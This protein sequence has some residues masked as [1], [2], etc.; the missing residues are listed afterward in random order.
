MPDF[1]PYRFSPQGNPFVA[2]PGGPVTPA[3]QLDDNFAACAAAL[4]PTNY[5]PGSDAAGLIAAIALGGGAAA[6][7][8]SNV[9]PSTGRD[10]L[11]ALATNL[12]N[13]STAILYPPGTFPFAADAALTAPLQCSIGTKFA[14]APGKILTISGAFDGPLTQLFDCD[15]GQVK[16]A[17]GAVKVVRPEWFR[18]PSD[19]DDTLSI[20]RARDSITSRGEVRF[21]VKAYSVSG[22]VGID[23][24]GIGYRGGGLFNTIFVNTST[25]EDTT[26]IDGTTAGAQLDW[27]YHLGIG[28]LRSPSLSATSTA[29]I[30]T[31]VKGFRHIL[32]VNAQITGTFADDP[33]PY[34]EAQTSGANI[35]IY[36][37]R[38]VKVG[39]T[40]ATIWY[41]FVSD[42]TIAGPASTSSN[43]SSRKKI[44]SLAKGFVGVSWGGFSYGNDLRDG[45]WDDLEVANT[46]H[47]WDCFAAG[48]TIQVFDFHMTRLVIDGWTGSGVRLANFP[49]GSKCYI[50]DGYSAP[51]AGVT[52][53]LP[54][55]R[56]TACSG[57]TVGP[58][59]EA[60]G[61]T[62]W[63]Q[64]VGYLLEGGSARCRLYGSA[65]GVNVGAQI[66]SSSL[67]WVSLAIEAQASQPMGAAVSIIG[68]ST[69]NVV[70]GC[71]IDGQGLTDFAIDIAAAATYNRVG[72]NTVNPGSITPTTGAVIRI[73]GTP[74]T[75]PGTYNF[76]QVLPGTL[77]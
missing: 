7:D 22:W 27:C 15:A 68:P 12:A 42:C 23:R 11:D 40:G 14:P 1:P 10:A 64:A 2:P 49:A 57:V 55:V 35:N 52:G 34:Y 59:F 70:A 47:G 48:S 50:G 5:P 53:V 77:D 39:D 38:G 26:G 62:N 20:R 46:T 21:L 56:I 24:A 72:L 61:A 73:S 44:I 69:R 65:T 60:K 16:F 28:T 19:P 51:A 32:A 45:F 41:G 6:T 31:G 76:N 13:V 4:N 9:D 67:N 66:D 29:G 75:T 54:A 63:A 3:R 33:I 30:P 74:V 71:V 25:T 36:T 37:V 43:G 8:F 58:G 17:D 18:K